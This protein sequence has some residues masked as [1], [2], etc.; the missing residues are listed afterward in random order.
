VPGIARAVLKAVGA[1]DWN[2]LQN[3]GRAAHQVVMHVHFHIIPR[4]E[5]HGLDLGWNAG[6][7][8]PASAGEL[9][10]KIKNAMSV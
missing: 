10:A 1:V 8:D 2:L 9:I 5:K 6:K 3:N 4:F 7:L